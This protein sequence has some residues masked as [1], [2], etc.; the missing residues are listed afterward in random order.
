MASVVYS[1]DK[2]EEIFYRENLKIPPISQRIWA[3]GID[4]I[5]VVLLTW[6]VYINLLS[7]SS[8]DIVSKIYSI[9]KLILTY[10]LLGFFYEVVMIRFFNASIGK[11][12][13][14]HR[15]ISLQTLDIPL[16]KTILQRSALKILEE[17][18]GFVLFIFAIDNSFHRGIHDRFSK[19]IVILER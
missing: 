16:F 8:G 12:I 17:I 11:M 5:L 10:F 2:I 9:Q 6:G 4:I 19:T 15:I 1:D 7:A 14:G 18:F 3:F 13:F